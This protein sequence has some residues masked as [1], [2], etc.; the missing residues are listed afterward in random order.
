MKKSR[1]SLWNPATRPIKGV[2]GPGVSVEGT[3]VGQGVCLA[4]APKWAGG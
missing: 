2:P 4:A 3:E 1:K